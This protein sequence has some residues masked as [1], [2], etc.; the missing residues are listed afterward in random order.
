M[1]N[2]KDCTKIRTNVLPFWKTKYKCNF[3]WSLM[4]L[5]SVQAFIFISACRTCA[6]EKNAAE[7]DLMRLLALYACCPLRCTS[8]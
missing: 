3:I 8:C 6:H 1:D 7:L 5:N 2:R 4:R